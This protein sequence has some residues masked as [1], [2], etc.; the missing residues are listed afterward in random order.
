[1]TLQ[2]TDWKVKREGTIQFSNHHLEM[3]KKSQYL[4]Q[5][6]EGTNHSKILSLLYILQTY[7]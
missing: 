7:M 2:I 6:L 4:S 1:M 5:Y 3:R